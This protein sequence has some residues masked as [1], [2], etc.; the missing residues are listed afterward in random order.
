[1]PPKISGIDH[2]HL[3]VPNKKEAEQWYRETLGFHVV[4]KLS[5]WDTEYG[6]LTIEDSSGQVHFALFESENFE[7]LTAVAFKTDGKSF[8]QWKDYLEAK[9]L[10][11]RCSDHKVAWSL[12]FLDPYGHSH[13][14]TTYDVDEVKS[15]I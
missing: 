2:I 15:G 13:E 5:V 4:E 7:P 14:I 3:Y 8:L 11:S 6:P 9:D 1:M 10:L 12:Y